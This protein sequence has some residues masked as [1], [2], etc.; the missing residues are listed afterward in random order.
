VDSKSE[1]AVRRFFSYSIGEDERKEVKEG[2]L[3]I[4]REIH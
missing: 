1:M 2:G 4:K 3:E